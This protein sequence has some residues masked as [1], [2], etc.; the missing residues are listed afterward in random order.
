MSPRSNDGHIVQGQG[1]GES[2]D[3]SKSASA[4]ETA[5]HSPQHGRTP[6]E[7]LLESVLEHS[8]HSLWVSDASGTMIRQNQACRDLLHITDD[9]VVGKY[10][11]LHD[12]IVEAQGHL[13]AVRAVFEDGAT[14]SF[15][16]L[17][18]T[19]ALEGIAFA[20]S[21]SRVLEVT[22][23][24]VFDAEGRVTRAVVQHV[25]V[26]ERERALAELRASQRELQAIFDTS[27]TGI[28]VTRAEDGTIVDANAAFL[29]LFGVEREQIIG[30]TSIELGMFED[31][32]DRSRMMAML[33]RDGRVQDLEVS[34]RIAGGDVRVVAVSAAPLESDGK[35]TL[36]GTI[37]DITQR[38]QMEQQLQR[39]ASDLERRVNERTAELSESIAEIESFSYSVS[40]D[41]RAPLR[42]ISG[43]A[44]MLAA[45]YGAVLDD[46]AHGYIDALSRSVREMGV[47]IDELLEFSRAGRASLDFGAADMGALVWEARELLEDTCEGRTIDWRIAPLPEVHGDAAML[48]QVWVNLLGNAVK[49]TR[50]VAQA[51]IEVRVHDTPAEHEFT[52]ADN[53]VGFDMQYVDKL[54]GVFQRLHADR[55]FEGVGI[56]LANV[57]RIVGRHGGRTWAEGVVGEGAVFG[58]SLP[59]SI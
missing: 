37:M 31:P 30:R 13:P 58:F 45:D 24:P 55:Q 54:F 57:R 43:F 39:L 25:D 9:E 4:G 33:E 59:R 27:P 19:A 16:L 28:F 20:E 47:L 15:V 5:D 2:V 32:G 51:R 49:Y 35:Q 10:N 40:H 52:V 50:P 46:T 44:G 56:G 3:M 7:A 53:G 18:D 11:M 42:H 34:V 41:L 6:S 26:T 14:A 8:P 29:R 1:D 23:S 21:V 17:Y 12:S 48:R 22:I 38:K 36:I